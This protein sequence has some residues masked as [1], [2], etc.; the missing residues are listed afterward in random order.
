VPPSSGW[1]GS[2]PEAAAV[3]GP[4]RVDP[5]QGGARG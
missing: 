4:M 2:A 3:V 5:A 1:S